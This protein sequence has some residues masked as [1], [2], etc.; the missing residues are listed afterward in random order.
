MVKLDFQLSQCCMMISQWVILAKECTNYMGFL[1]PGEQA[2]AGYQILYSPGSL[3]S[4]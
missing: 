3:G 4:S 1:G 2:S